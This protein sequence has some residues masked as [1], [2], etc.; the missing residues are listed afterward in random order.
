M[1]IR[2]V[3]DNQ[4]I[5]VLLLKTE[6]ITCKVIKIIIQNYHKRNRIITN[7]VRVCGL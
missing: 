2:N 4:K 5:E 6:I 7:Q 1:V 3:K